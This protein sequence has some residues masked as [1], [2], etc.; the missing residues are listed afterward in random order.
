[1]L[2]NWS[3]TACGVC[4]T[5]GVRE[6]RQVTSGSSVVE[7]G[8]MLSIVF[9][10]CAKGP[11]Q[12]SWPKSIVVNRRELVGKLACFLGT[13]SSYYKVYAAAPGDSSTNYDRVDLYGA[14]E[15]V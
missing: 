9:G 6:S 2:G 10:N 4:S 15:F 3:G 7:S 13:G 5:N 8:S 11:R 12:P 14:N 1:M